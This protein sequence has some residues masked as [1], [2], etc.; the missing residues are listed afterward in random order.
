MIIWVNGSFGSGKTTLS[1]ILLEKIP[2]S[3]LF[4]PEEIGGLIHRIVPNS[5]SKDFQDFKMW[6][7]IVVQYLNGLHNEFKLPMIVPM[8]L[9]NLNYIDE[10]FSSLYELDVDF[11]HFYLDIDEDILRSR[12]NAQI[13]HA[14]DSEKDQWIR[15]WRL[16]RVSKCLEA[17]KFMPNETYFLDSGKMN[18]GELADTVLEI[19]N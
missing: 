2:N 12:I 15:D 19:I 10:I 18:P 11:K 9:V 8:T 4:D 3:I 7:E 5:K 13:I 14:S 17:K 16:E 1:K 6:R